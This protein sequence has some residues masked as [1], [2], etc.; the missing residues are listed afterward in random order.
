MN[1]IQFVKRRVRIGK[2]CPL[3]KTEGIVF[4]NTDRPRL[5]SYIFFDEILERKKKKEP[6]LD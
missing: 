3:L 6:G 1:V 4:L 2:N 5:V